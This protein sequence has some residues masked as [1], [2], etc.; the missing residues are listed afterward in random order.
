ML[1]ESKRFSLSRLGA[2]TVLAL[3]LAGLAF[4]LNAPRAQPSAGGASADPEKRVPAMREKVYVLFARAQSC[5]DAEDRDCARDALSAIERMSLNDYETAQLWYFRAFIHFQEDDIPRAIAAYENVLRI[6]NDVPAGL[7]QR[8]LI[9]LAQLYA[10]NEQ[11][12]QGLEALVEWF[13]REEAPGPTAFVLR[14][15]IE[16]QLGRH[17][18]ALRSINEGIERAAQPGEGWYTMRLALQLEQDDQ[19]GAIETL[20]LLNEKWPSEERA[21]QLE[22][23]EASAN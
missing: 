9:S 11:P 12:E 23:L 15:S 17:E 3:V 13:E 4:S 7:R 10:S 20:K 6:S 1:E 16:Y 5:M 19:A 2:R 14:A 18:A 22:Q 21:L 8:T